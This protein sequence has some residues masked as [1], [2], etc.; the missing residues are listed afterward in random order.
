MTAFTRGETGL[1]VAVAA[2]EP[3]VAG[4]RRLH[5]PAAR[6]GV[7][8][9]VTLCYPFLPQDAV[10]AGVLADLRALVAAVPAFDVVFARSARFPGDVL[11]LEPS[12]DAPF[13]ALT[14]EL[15]RRWPEAPPYGGAYPDPVP[16]LTVTDGADPDTTDAVQAALDGGLPV[17]ARVTEAQLVAFDGHRWLTAASFSFG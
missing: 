5:D 9:H 16:H 13:R 12:P 7:P 10:D 2:A 15:W 1:I 4:H 6:Y 11:Y 14:A 17:S 8:A 3:V